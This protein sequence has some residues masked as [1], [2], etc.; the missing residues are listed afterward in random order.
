MSISRKKTFYFLTLSSS[1]SLGIIAVLSLY[2]IN[3]NSIVESYITIEGALGVVL[4]ISLRIVIVSGMTL[5]TFYQWFKQEDQYLSD[6]PFLFGLYFVFLVFGKALDLYSAF[7][8]FQ[9]NDFIVLTIIKVR[10][11]IMILN[12]LPMIYLSSEMI[13]FSFSLKPRFKLLTN[14]RTRNKINIRFIMVII[15]IESIAGILASNQRTLSIYY[16]VIVIPSLLTIVWL[17]NFARKNKRLSQV[18][19]L[20]LTIGFGAYLISQILRPLA[21][22]IIGESAMFLILAETL[23]L[24]IFIIIFLGFY[25]ES[26]Y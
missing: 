7:I 19:T 16:P 18:N 4:T 13:L 22:F 25:G 9:L 20:T 26:H 3:W 1:V 17:F 21:Q 2:F 5:Y 10:F 14:E 23:D 12:F 15:F 11:F 24:I 8:F 6:L